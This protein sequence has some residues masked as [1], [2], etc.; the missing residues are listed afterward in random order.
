MNRKGVMFDMFGVLCCP[1][2]PEQRIIEEYGLDPGIHDRLQR[3]VCGYKFNGNWESYISNIIDASGIEKTVKNA[4]R[5]K[6]LCFSEYDKGLRSV[7]AEA[8]DV[9]GRLKGEGY[10]LGLVSNAYP[11]SRNIIEENGLLEFFDDGAVIFSYEVG[12]TKQ[13]PEI[14]RLCLERLDVPAEDAV[15]IGDSFKSD[16]LAASA[17]TNGEMGGILLSKKPTA[18]AT[19]SGCIIISSLD[20]VP[21]AV[22]KYFENK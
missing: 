9:L 16:I 11:P 5:I 3:A 7:P 18:E 14:F 10:A 1:T 19:K 6:G 22:R 20:K 8:K 15:M 12:M 2:S 21:E 17:A 13:N 4:T